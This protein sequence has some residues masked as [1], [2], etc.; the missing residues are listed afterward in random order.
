MAHDEVIAIKITRK[1]KAAGASSGTYLW[2]AKKKKKTEK[3]ETKR[4]KKKREKRA[5][6]EER[7]KA[8]ERNEIIFV[9]RF[10]SAREKYLKSKSAVG[11]PGGGFPGGG[12][13]GGGSNRGRQSGPCNTRQWQKLLPII[14]I[15]DSHDRI[16]IL[17]RSVPS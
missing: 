11:G 9:V 4:K 12:F 3:R 1:R 16:E 10:I 7:K 15:C 2:I 6:R 17:Y 13:P 14:I 5:V 8:H